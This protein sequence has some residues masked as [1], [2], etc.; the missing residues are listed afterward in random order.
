MPASRSLAMLDSIPVPSATLVLADIVT[1]AR[2]SLCNQLKLPMLA[3]SSK[4]DVVALSSACEELCGP[5][6]ARNW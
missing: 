2:S 3:L 5:V 1:W 6:R 4:G